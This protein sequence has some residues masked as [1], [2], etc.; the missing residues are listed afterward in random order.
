[1]W[2]PGLSVCLMMLLMAFTTYTICGEALIP[3]SVGREMQGGESFILHKVEKGEGWYSIAKKY[4]ISYASLRLANKDS[5]VI[6]ITGQ[7]VRVPSKP[8]VNDPRFQ[9]N[10]PDTK[11]QDASA[12]QTGKKPK[13][14]AYHTV[15]ASET[16][17]SISRQYKCTVE[18]LKEWNR[19]TSNS[20]HAGQKLIVGF[21][22]GITPKTEE[23]SAVVPVDTPQPVKPSPQP[24]NSESGALHATPPAGDHTEP[25]EPKP[26]FPDKNDLTK[27]EPDPDRTFTFSGN[28][29]EV[30]EQGTAA[31]VGEEEVNPNK[32]FALHRTCPV[33]TIIRVTRKENGQSVFVKVV[34]KIPD[35]P[36][37]QG[38]IIKISKAAAEKLGT[39]ESRFEA[40]LLYGIAKQ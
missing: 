2:R 23:K 16:L 25:A 28:M 17:Y 3:D 35:I 33:G 29:Q 37:N 21:E 12:D 40:E 1:M 5:G 34:G 15:K 36:E 38:L 18:E 6:L 32:Y 8:K 39:N 20:I 19:L 11:K 31:W 26:V 10:Y 30:H 9:K 27:K 7:V 22:T 13:A 4:G 24:E 14:A